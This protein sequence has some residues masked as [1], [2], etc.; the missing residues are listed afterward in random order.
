MRHCCV[1]DGGWLSAFAR[2]VCLEGAGEVG[3][4]ANKHA[5]VIMHARVVVNNVVM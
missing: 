3:G 2:A 5:F 4:N 1:A